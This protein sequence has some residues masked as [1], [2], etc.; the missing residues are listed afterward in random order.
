VAA[1]LVQGNLGAM[2]MD[3]PAPKGDPCKGE[4]N[5]LTNH[6]LLQCYDKD[7]VLISM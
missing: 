7:G 1:L 5:E 3:A 4:Y 2:M 6:F